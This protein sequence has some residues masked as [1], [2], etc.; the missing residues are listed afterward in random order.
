MPVYGINDHGPLVIAT[1]VDEAVIGVLKTWMPTYL[2]L[3]STERNLTDPAT[4][5][6][7]VLPAPVS[8]SN[9]I[10]P[11][12]IMDHPTP[13]IVVTTA[14]VISTVGG[15]NSIYQAVWLV[16]VSA[17]VRGRSPVESKKT[18]ALFEGAIRRCMTEKARENAGPLNGAHWV[19][20]E[21]APVAAGTRE[22]RYLAAGMGTYHV[23]TDAAVRSFGGPDVPDADSYAPVATVENGGVV[24]TVVEKT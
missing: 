14:K 11:D 6:N 1:D 15:A 21:V 18:A 22:G 3:L 9:Y 10:N 24:V 12:E 23:S 4:S 16:R 8:Y 17:I 13:G 5:K 19:D 2:R 20:C 7:Y